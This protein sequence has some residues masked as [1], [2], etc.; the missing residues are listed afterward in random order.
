[1][2]VKHPHQPLRS[3][4]DETINKILEW[5]SKGLIPSGGGISVALR[6]LQARRRYRATDEAIEFLEALNN[7]GV[8][9]DAVL[10]ILQGKK[11]PAIDVFRLYT[12]RMVMEDDYRETS[13]KGKALRALEL[14]FKQLER[15]KDTVL[16]N[17]LLS[18][19][20]REEYRKEFIIIQDA[21]S[22]ICSI[23]TVPTL[24]PSDN[25]TVN[26]VDPRK[27]HKS[28]DDWSRQGFWNPILQALIPL[29]THTNLTTYRALKDLAL[30]LSLLFPPFPNKPNLLKRR[31]Y[32]SFISSRLG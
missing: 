21:I 9:K 16:N 32:H 29:W 19:S 12:E 17:D 25:F 13:R 6:Q 8:K 1:M 30:L 3:T 27:R 23:K 7:Q 31:H 14:K 15:V 11:P 28:D 5:K 22:R 18:N 20:L 10:A 26:V 2:N 24:K 4:R